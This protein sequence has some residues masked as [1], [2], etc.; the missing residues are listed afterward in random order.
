MIRML[1][2]IDRFKMQI[3]FFL[4]A[5]FSICIIPT[6][7][8]YAETD[9]T[10]PEWPKIIGS[11]WMND[12]INDDEFLHSIEFLIKEEIILIPYNSIIHTS[13]LPDW[14]LHNAGW[15]H[16]RIA[17]GSD[18]A[19]FDSSYIGERILLYSGGLWGDIPEDVDTP[20]DYTSNE[21]RT[22]ISRNL[23]DKELSPEISK[24]KP[25]NTYRIFAVGGSTTFGVDIDNSETWPAYLEQKF[26]KFNL[27][28]S[29]EVVN[30]GKN[31]SDTKDELKLIQNKLIDFEPDMIIMYSGWNDNL[32]ANKKPVIY[33]DGTI[34]NWK[35]V[36]ELGNTKNFDTIVILQPVTG[37]GD[38]IPTTQESMSFDKTRPESFYHEPRVLENLLII[39]QNLH[40]LNEKCTTVLDF[41]HIFDYIQSPI[42]FD[43]GHTDSLGNKII[44]DNII[45]EIFSIILPST[46]YVE[47]NDLLEYDGNSNTTVYAHSS[48]LS[49]KNF[50]NLDLT[51]AV[52]YKT[53]LSNSSFKNT[54][55]DGVILKGANLS[56]VDLSDVDLSGK[57][58]TGTI[59]TG[60][61]LSGKDL[62]G[63]ILTGADLTNA[64]LP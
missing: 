37:S 3:L 9:Y 20:A 28:F 11:W 40:L 46:V 22:N 45:S 34:E 63:T 43:S 26:K 31:G 15:W 64:I 14:L 47:I 10:I 49:G 39:S 53:N 18:F 33:P 17:T 27:D 30:A 29:V 1:K 44:A 5:I 32:Q 2:D 35:K 6:E 19:N 16:A 60:V 54:I 56:G 12:Q 4:V 13:E 58:L 57:D 21:F 51:N 61:D 42:Y 59:L 62:T 50:D 36:C 8:A 7:L 52:F 23:W 38:R 25:D 55:L 41:T 48:D 24:K